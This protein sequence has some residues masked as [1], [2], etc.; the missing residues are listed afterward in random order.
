M[1]NGLIYIY[2]RT[3]TH[4][5]TRIY[6]HVHIHIDRCIILYCLIF[7][8]KAMPMARLMAWSIFLLSTADAMLGRVS[9]ALVKG[10]GL[11]DGHFD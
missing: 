11:S 6:V 1:Y 2:V 3:P 7:S 9:S 4:T 8:A 10:L 5:Y